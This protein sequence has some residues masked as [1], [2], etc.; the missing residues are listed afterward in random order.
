[1]TMHE[2][3]IVKSIFGSSVRWDLISIDPGSFPAK[4]NWTRAYVMFQTI[5]FYSAI[6]DHTLIHEMVHIWQYEKWGSAYITEALWAQR[7]GGGYNYG[8]VERLQQLASKGLHAFNMEKQADI[9]E[10]YYR[11]KNGLPLQWALNVPGVGELLERYHEDV[12]R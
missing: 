4:K 5:N 12:R 1:M 10:D 6:P 11:W 9:I 7:W 2:I 8:G 3:D